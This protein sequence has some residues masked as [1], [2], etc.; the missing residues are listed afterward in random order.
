MGGKWSISLNLAGVTVRDPTQQG[1]PTGIYKVLLNDSDITQSDDPSK[2]PSVKLTCIVQEGEHKGAEVFVWM[3]L[4]ASKKGVQ[5]SWKTLLASVG[6]PPAMLEGPITIAPESLQ[7]K[8]GTLYIRAKNPDEKEGY[9]Q[10]DFV[11][12]D[13][14]TK[15]LASLKATEAAVPANGAPAGA[16]QAGA[17]TPQ[18]TAG[19][20]AG[21]AGA[22]RF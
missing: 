11:T 8:L 4:D 16:P 10:R 13:M 14:A 6:A 19:G 18:P 5:R 22:M 12:A 1:L 15:I 9:D 2:G 7:G 17:A 3:G 20:A 21:A